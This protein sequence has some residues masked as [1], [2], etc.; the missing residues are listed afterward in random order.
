MADLPSGPTVLIVDRDF[1]FAFWLAE[2]FTE[3]GCHPVPALDCAKA[4]SL[5][6][7]LEKVDMVVLDP[8]MPACSKMMQSLTRLHPSVKLVAVVGEKTDSNIAA[9]AVLKRPSGLM[10]ISRQ[11]WVRRVRQVLRDVEIVGNA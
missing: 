3:L 6:P 9:D 2:I 11:E 8:T 7:E 4:V 10:P 1:G 5:T